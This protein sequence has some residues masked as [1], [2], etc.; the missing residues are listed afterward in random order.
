MYKKA[1]PLFLVAFLL[2]AGCAPSASLSATDITSRSGVALATPAQDQRNAPAQDGRNTSAQDSRNAPAQDRRSAAPVPAQSEQNAACHPD[3]DKASAA[4]KI[5]AEELKTA[6]GEPG[7]GRPDMAAVAVKLNIS[8]DV[9][10]QAMQQAMPAEC[11]APG[12]QP[13]PDGACH[14]DLE[15]AAAALKISTEQLQTALGEPGQGHPD[16]AA[17]AVKLNISLDVLQQAM[18]QAM[19]ADCPAPGDGPTH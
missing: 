9:L 16:M 13:G 3:L 5:S 17:V 7:Q 11:P 1:V 12:D 14:P 15:K 6:L 19:P 8:L 10:Q 18:Q 4:L 2:L